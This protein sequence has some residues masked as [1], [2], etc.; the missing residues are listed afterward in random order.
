MTEKIDI[1]N[2]F[3]EYFFDNQKKIIDNDGKIILD[4]NELDKLSSEVVDYILAEPENALIKIRKAFDSIDLPIKKDNI[5]FGFENPPDNHKISIGECSLPDW[6]NK[7]VEIKGILSSISSIKPTI[8]KGRFYC[9]RCGKQM[10]YD[11]GLYDWMKRK[12][13]CKEC[14]RPTMHR[15]EE[16]ESVK[17]KT[18][19]ITVNEPYSFTTAPPK[20]DVWLLEKLTD[21][22]KTSEKTLLSGIEIKIVGIMKHQV[23]P[24]TTAMMP[25][26]KAVYWDAK[27]KMVTITKEDE[28]KI[29]KM[30]KK[31]TLIKDLIDSIAPTIYGHDAEKE[32]IL[33]MLI[34]GN[35]ILKPDGTHRR[36]N[37]HI[38]F[39]GDPSS[40]KTR[41]GEWIIRNFPRARYVVGSEATAAGLSA[42]MRKDNQT[43]FWVVDPGALVM[44]NLSTCVVDEMDKLK[45][46]DLGPLDQVMEMQ[47]LVI[48]K[49]GVDADFPSEVNILGILNPVHGRYDPF[50]SIDE[51]VKI[52]DTTLSRFD[53]KFLFQDKP[54]EKK[55]RG[56]LEA[57]THPEKFK[58]KIESEFLVKYIL[59]AREI[60]PKLNKN[61]EKSLQDFFLSLRDKFSQNK[62]MAITAR[63]YEATLRLSEAYAK[64]RLSSTISIEDTKRAINLMKASIRQFGLDT[65]TG[66]IDIDQAEGRMSKSK[67]DRLLQFM[68]VFEDMRKQ[69]GENVPIEDLITRSV[70]TIEGFKSRQ[71]VI[72]IIIKLKN[73]GVFFSPRPDFITKVDYN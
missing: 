43:G 53:I 25:Y 24:K 23:L 2:F 44:A 41:L 21:S 49:A 9:N 17:I 12:F 5:H 13:F 36:G 14:E 54:E 52:R 27:T 38:M 62:V 64:L 20:I 3:S 8:I 58:P 18:Q 70:D 42:S 72:N 4:L 34:G 28:E 22:T 16:S 39:I 35:K 29:K 47:R 61:I 66:I 40:G 59:Y 57:M 1:E 67:R 26:L 50:Q 65:E 48:T 73:D 51:Q 56:M 63:Q 11:F 6:N 7:L 19:M 68:D 60:E 15:L 69:F 46:E 30:S 31:K 10:D 32:A 33:L 71:D 45:P 55:D 37:I